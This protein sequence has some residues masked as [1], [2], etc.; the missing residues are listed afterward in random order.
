MIYYIQ[1]GEEMKCYFCGKD[2]KDGE[3]RFVIVDMDYI[4][5]EK[6]RDEYMG[7]LLRGDWIDNMIK[8]EDKY[9]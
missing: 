2:I 3:R 5:C 4:A 6:C 1:G 9:E 8:G 7:F